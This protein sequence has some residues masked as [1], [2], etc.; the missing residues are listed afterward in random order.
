MNL[1]EAIQAVKDLRNATGAR[2]MDCKAALEEAGGDQAKAIE[3]L[4]T[5]N[6]IISGV[7]AEKQA[8]EGLIGH[9]CK[10]SALS[11]VVLTSTTDFVTRNPDF[12]SLL[13]SL[14]KLSHDNKAS[15]KASLEAMELNGR[16]VLDLVNEMAGKV[17][18]RVTIRE[19][20]YA[21]QPFGFYVHHDS[22]QAA[23][24]HCHSTE[25]Q[26]GESS[27]MGDG[28]DISMHIVSAKPVPVCVD[29]SG[30][31]ADDAAK[32]RAI[33]TERLKADPKNAKKPPQIIE[34]IIEGQMGKFYAERCLLEQPYYREGSKTV[35]QVLAEKKLAVTAFRYI[36]VGL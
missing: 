17:G 32:E 3:I 15:D 10:N 25:K 23:V 28:K 31:P 21:E 19:V 6:I 16:K 2:L 18:E 4:R 30:V 24:V 14:V 34:K 26:E 12:T 27:L 11:L 13:D 29:R 9:V 5:R 22:K 33:L 8:N 1:K 7:M 35:A 36:K 20:I